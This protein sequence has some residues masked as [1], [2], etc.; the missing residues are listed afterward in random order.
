MGTGQYAG[1][2]YVLSSSHGL[3]TLPDPIPPYVL[4]PQV[5]DSDGPSG[6]SGPGGPQLFELQAQVPLRHHRHAHTDHAAS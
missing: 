6:S 1:E 2:V 3:S 4:A 5:G